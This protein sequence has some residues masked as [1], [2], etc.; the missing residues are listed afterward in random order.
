[1]PECNSNKS[2]NNWNF[3]MQR[4]AH[5][6]PFAFFISSIPYLLMFMSINFCFK[7]EFLSFGK[8]LLDKLF[9]YNCYIRIVSKND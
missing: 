3:S 7:K 1:M 4:R 5:P 8:G 9:I 2:N 6:S